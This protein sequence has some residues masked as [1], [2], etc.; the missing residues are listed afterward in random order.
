M[1]VAAVT[2]VVFGFAWQGAVGGPDHALFVGGKAWSGIAAGHFFLRGVPLDLSPAGLTVLLQMFTVGLAA[3]IPLSSGSDRWRLSAACFSTIL[4]AGWTYPLFAH[5][6]WGGGWLAQLGVNRGLG[7]GLIDG[8]GSGT[9]QSVGGL[10]ALSISWILGPRRGKYSA[11]GM[12]AAMPGHNVVLVLLG[13][14]FAWLGWLGLNSS[15][16]IL[17]AGVSPSQ[18]VLVAVDTTLSAAAS[19]LAT[20]SVTR[21][22]FGRPDASLV[23]NGWVAGLVASSAGAG[24]V[25]PAAA[26]IIGLVAGILIPF[27]VDLLEFR[28]AI[29]DPA[30][31]ISVHAMAGLWGLFAVAILPDAKPSAASGQWLAQLI[32]IAT[33]L[34]LI[35]PLSYGLNYLLDRVHPQRVVEEGEQQGMDLYELGASAYPEFATHNEEF[36]PH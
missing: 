34:G 6:V 7:D 14:V 29:D 21:Y 17:F 4:L 18:V 10:T 25:K 33:L 2:Y 19:A 5:W 30:G 8:G 26:M 36:M 22:R 28:F 24:L 16:A 12:P 35:L 31:A 1:G 11:D 32:G 23:A 13:C 20:L 27:A 3:L 9:I 15:G